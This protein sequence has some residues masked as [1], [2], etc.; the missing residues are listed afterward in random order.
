MGFKAKLFEVILY[1]DSSDFSDLQGY[2]AGRSG[3]RNYAYIVHDKDKNKTHCHYMLRMNDTYSSDSIARWFGVS[4]NQVERCKGRWSDMLSYLIHLNAPDKYQYDRSCVFSNFDWEKVVRA[5]NEKKKSAVRIN[6]IVAGIAD[7]DIR[8]Y[9]IH[10]YVSVHEYVKYKGQINSAFEYRNK[11]IKGVDREMKSIYIY[12]GSGTGKTTLAKKIAL[13]QGYSVFISSGSNDVLDDYE[14]Q[15]CIILDDLRP[16]CLGLSDLLKMLDPRTAST[17]KSRYYNK[18]LECKLI[19]ITTT[20]PM[21]EFFNS[22]FENESEPLRQLQ[23]RCQTKIYVT[24]SEIYTSIYDETD[25]VYRD[26]PVAPNFVLKAMRLKRM[27]MPEMMKHASEL[28][29]GLCDFSA[30]VK[31]YQKTQKIQKTQ[32]TKKQNLVNNFSAVFPAFEILS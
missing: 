14:G 30:E 1:S 12:G 27:T 18:T 24:E 5:A 22:V 15:D 9:N 25:H 4:G 8:R 16:S 7:G 11:K 13:N 17:V 2:I 3:I 28:Y 32:K 10:E 20:R 19:I 21:S 6:E 29:G 31:E 23:R 26:L